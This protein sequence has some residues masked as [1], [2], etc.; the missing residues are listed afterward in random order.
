[1]YG[2]L[3]SELAHQLVAQRNVPLVNEWK[4]SPNTPIGGYWYMSPADTKYYNVFSLRGAPPL[5]AGTLMKLKK[6]IPRLF[7]VHEPGEGEW[8]LKDLDLYKDQCDAMNAML[9]KQPVITK[10]WQAKIYEEM[11][12]AVNGMATPKTDFADFSPEVMLLLK[13]STQYTTT[14]GVPTFEPEPAK[15]PVPLVLPEAPPEAPWAF[16]DYAVVRFL[17][18]C[19]NSSTRNADEDRVMVRQVFVK[20]PGRP[21]TVEELPQ[22]VQPRLMNAISSAMV[23]VNAAIDFYCLPLSMEAIIERMEEQY[24]AP[25]ANALIAVIQS[26]YSSNSL[27]DIPKRAT[28]YQ[29]DTSYRQQ[30]G[31]IRNLKETLAQFAHNRRRRI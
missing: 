25:I 20:D 5:D 30:A 13:Q 18:R 9:D 15:V 16:L 8:S 7:L 14:I 10:E 6:S 21:I 1:M 26:S 31:F 22:Y 11:K 4:P 28:K 12:R 23:I 2:V 3:D 19:V 29:I 27:M 24:I 17:M